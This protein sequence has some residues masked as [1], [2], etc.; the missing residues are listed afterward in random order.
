MPACGVNTGPAIYA[1]NPHSPW[2]R[3]TDENTNGLLQRYVPKDPHLSACGPDELAAVA[4]VP[5]N[6]LCRTLGWGSPAETS[7]AV[8]RAGQ[9]GVAMTARDRA[10]GFEA[11]SAE[12]H[13]AG[14]GKRHV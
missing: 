7:D 10:Q 13:R 6:R 9:A 4:V 14:R 1:C 5:N 8:P 2:Q 11:P 12:H 3:G